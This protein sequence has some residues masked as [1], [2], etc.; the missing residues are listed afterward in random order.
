MLT[1]RRCVTGLI[2]FVIVIHCWF[3][4]I[5]FPFFQ[6]QARELRWKWDKLTITDIYFPCSFF[7]GV[8]DS[9]IQVEGNVSVNG[10]IK[11][12]NWLVFEDYLNLPKHERAN[13]ACQR[14]TRYKEDIQRIKELGMNMYRFSICWSKIEPQEGVFDQQALNHYIDVVDTLLA[15]G[16]TPMI[17][18]FHHT[19]PAWLDEKGGF[20]VF[21]NFYY[22]F[23]FADFV[24][25]RLHTKVRYWITFNEPIAFALEAFYRGT[26]PPSSKSFKCAGKVA[27]N[28]LFSHVEVARHF[29]TIDPQVNI[30]IA[31]IYNPLDAYTSWNPFEHL[32]AKF[33][34]QVI[35]DLTITFFKTGKFNWGFLV[36]DYLEEAPQSLDFI[37]VNYY[38]NTIIRQT[39]L[40]RIET[41]VRETDK[42]TTA[43]I[44]DPS[45]DILYP[46]K[47]IYAEGLYRAIQSAAQLNIPIFITENG[48]NSTCGADVQD[49][50]IKKHLYVVS[51]ALDEGYPIKG[52]LYWSLTD[53]FCWRR[54]YRNKNGIFALDFQTQERT[55]RPV[56]N[57]LIDVIKRSRGIS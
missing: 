3:S 39:G 2:K 23:R 21:S 54:G 50:Y 10:P 32:A 47:V 16:I 34:N 18:L 29:K 41:A 17:T 26:Y 31:H 7:W 11:T 48:S 9:A 22:F 4:L 28:M 19:Y 56:F 24:F 33:F 40:F 6:T 5:C 43:K 42:I 36:R 52:Y 46:S 30:G 20:A 27:R 25:R 35:N 37:G 14:W 13:D 12:D 57:Y 49:E 8:S 51:R 53:C 55:F 45:K 44:D 15:Q 1:I 38:T